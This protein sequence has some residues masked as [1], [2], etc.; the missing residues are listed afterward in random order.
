MILSN[1]YSNDRKDNFLNKMMEV[2][3]VNKKKI[4]ILA[5]TLF[6][7]MSLGA[8][9]KAKEDEFTV[10]Q[11]ESESVDSE[12]NNDENTESEDSQINKD[13]NT[14]S[15]DSGIKKEEDT[16]TENSSIKQPQSSMQKVEGTEEK[17][18]S[19][20]LLDLFVN[21]SIDAVDSKDM[22]SKY[23]IADFHIGSGEKNSYSIGEKMD[24]DNDG[25]NELIIRG[26]YGGVYFDARDNKVYAFARGDG[27]A[28][29]LSYTYYNGEIWI[30]YSNSVNEGAE[31]YHME[32]Y[33][34]ADKLVAKMNFSE[35]F[36]DANNPKAGKKYV[37]NGKEISS[38]EY[39][40]FA[41]KIFAAEE[42]T[43]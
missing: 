10:T 43:D 36:A 29:I 5:C 41:S 38:D 15:K 25:E 8:C 19:D 33:E 23:S 17:L 11:Q 27:D 26:T 7:V 28:N 42:S 3:I 2:W 18:T 40:S 34:G 14:E 13:E 39:A 35:K 1:K 37:L 4:T 9:G 30:L 6:M 16:D 20:Q 21:G 32:K 22:T 24:L 12:I 31:S